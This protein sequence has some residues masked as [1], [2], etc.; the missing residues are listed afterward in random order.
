MPEQSKHPFRAKPAAA[1]TAA[2]IA[3]MIFNG[4]WPAWADQQQHTDQPASPATAETIVLPDATWLCVKDDGYRGIWYWNQKQGDEYV[5]KYAGGLGTYC[6]H[7]YPFAVYVPEV[8]KTFFCYGGAEAERNVL[9]HMVSYYDHRTG[10]V[11]R[12]TALLNKR[13]DDAHDNPVISV[14]GRGHIWIFSS[15][16]GRA[17]HAYVA[18]SKRPY[19]ID[20]FELVDITN[21]SYPQVYWTEGEGFAFFYTSY[22]LGK[23]F[24]FCTRSADGRSWREHTMLAAIQ[25]GHYQV[26]ASRGRKLAAAFNYH[27]H[28]LGLNWRTNLYYMESD[29]YGARWQAAD[30]TPLCLPLTEV[31]NP[32]LVHDYAAEDL[33]VYLVDMVLDNEDR[34]IIVFITSRGWKAG[35]ENGPRIWHTARWDG[36]RWNIR[37]AV[38]SDNNYDNGSLYVEEDGTWI[39]VAPTEL[40]PQPFNT[41]GEVAMWQSKDQGASW[42]KIRQ[43]TWGSEFN[44]GYCRRPIRVHPQFYALWA[45]GHGRQPSPSRL[46][47]C[48]RQGNVYR[49]PPKMDGEFARP[50]LIRSATETH[51]VS[52]ES[53]LRAACL[54]HDPAITKGG[55]VVDAGAGLSWSDL[56]EPVGRAAQFVHSPDLSTEQPRDA[57]PDGSGGEGSMPE[58]ADRSAVALG[59]RP[60]VLPSTA[61][62]EVLPPNLPPEFTTKV[63]ITPDLCQT[64][65]LFA[66]LPEAGRNLCGPTAFVNILLSLEG[67]PWQA[68]LPPEADE[69]HKARVLLELL[70]DRYLHMTPQG[71]SPIAAM[72]GIDRFLEEHGVERQIEW[73]GW[74]YGGRFASGRTVDVAW[75][76]ESVLGDS[77]ALLNVGWYRIGSTPVEFRRFGG[78]WVTLVGYRQTAEGLVLLVHDPARRSGPGK[79]THE[80]R[81]ERI[82]DGEL[83]P[84][85]DYRAQSARGLYR[86]VGLVLHPQADCALLDGAIR[87]ELRPTATRPTLSES[88][89]SA[90][91]GN[92]AHSR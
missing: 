48:D 53:S 38:E 82:D 44:H 75:L 29:D 92:A 16:H 68:I 34:P 79:V 70:T 72:N 27:P 18:V 73:R 67:G 62:Y 3:L 52:P 87:I 47:F 91:P 58:T 7:H 37:P 84:W 57:S 89:P 1:L 46:Y 74:R 45:D 63:A 23:R 85:G 13:T 41:G 20:D 26:S 31:Y 22:L 4:I 14:D 61:A 40:G 51:I 65:P 35:P 28:P 78:H 59:S 33:R 88:A 64:D 54:G 24:L 19:D 15:A 9:V 11:P 77:W 81:L 86:L 2:A 21:F 56:S 10:L 39:L 36:R 76:C 12:P 49:L 66:H 6:A 60:S 55:G 43:L 90:S 5:Y 30:G 83:A 80:V 42:Q 17:R 32:A 71:I 25:E 8:E 69:V 50:E